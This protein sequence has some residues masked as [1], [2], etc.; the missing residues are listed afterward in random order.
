MKRFLKIFGLCFGCTIVGIALIFGFAWLFGAFTEKPVKP[1]DIAFVKEE[2][3][4]STAVALRV[5]TKTKDV[6]QKNINISVY[7]KG[8]LDVPSKVTLG[9]DFIAWPIKADDGYN[10]GGIVKVKADFNGLLIAECY[11]KVDVPVHEIVV[12][13]EHTTLSK[14]EQISFGTDVV[15]ARA[16]NPWQTDSIPSDMNLYD[17]RQKSLYYFLYD[18]EGFLMDTSKA[19]FYTAKYGATNKLLV[20]EANLNAKIIATEICSFY[21]KAFCFPTFAKE[22]REAI[23]SANDLIHKEL[24]QVDQKYL[25]LLTEASSPSGDND[26]QFVNVAD[27]YI[28]SFTS[29]TERINAFLYET[30]Y[31]AARNASPESTAFNLDMKLHP[32]EGSSGYT[33]ENLDAFIDNIIL[34]W[35][36]EGTEVEVIKQGQFTEGTPADWKWSIRPKTYNKDFEPAELKATIKYLDKD[37]EE[38]T[39]ERNFYVDIRT[40]A[41]AGITADK[42]EDENGEY[43]EYISLNS[44]STETDSIKL[45]EGFTSTTTA[46]GLLS[47]SYKYFT[48][49]PDTA[50]PYSTFSL[51]KFFL[52]S[53]TVTKPT[54]TGNYKVTF[55]FEIKKADNYRI[56]LPS[57]D[58][59]Q[60]EISYFKLN[61]GTGEYEEAPAPSGETKGKYR[62]EF[63]YTKSSAVAATDDFFIGDTSEPI[64]INNLLYFEEGSEYPFCEV[65]GV[66]IKTF[67]NSDTMVITRQMAEITA[68]GYGNFT[69]YA[70][71][72]VADNNGAIIYDEDGNFTTLTT[73]P[74]EVKVTNSVKSISLNISDSTGGTNGVDEGDFNRNVVIDENSDYYIYIGPTEE[75]AL[76]VLTQA[77]EKENFKVTYKVKAQYKNADDMVINS[78]SLTIGEIVEDIDAT[79]TTLIGYKFL[80]QVGNV[81][82]V[83]G[84][85]GE[86]ASILFNITF[87]VSGS[88]FTLTKVIEVRD[89]VLKEAEI[90]YGESSVNTMQI[91]ARDV[92]EGGTIKWQE[93]SNSADVD[94]TKFS[95]NFASEYGNVNVAPNI[96]FRATNHTVNLDNLV[97]AVAGE[98]GK[99]QLSIKNVPYFTD[100]IDVVITM[101]YS[102]S[103]DTINKRYVYNDRLQIYELESYEDTTATYNLKIYGFN[104]SYDI[105]NQSIVGIKG[106]PVNIID[107]SYVTI[108]IKAAKGET[109]NKPIT[110]M[111][112]FSMIN[113]EYLSFSGTTIEI[114]KSI[115]TPQQATVTLMIGSNTFTTHNLTFKSP[116]TITQNNVPVIEA[117]AADVNIATAFSIK[118][119]T[120]VVDPRLIKFSFGDSVIPQNDRKVSDYVSITSDGKVSVKYVPYDFGVDVHITIYEQIDDTL[121]YGAD[122][123]EDKG[124]WVDFKLSIINDYYSNNSV[125]V[126]TNAGLGN[127][128]YG[129]HQNNYINIDDVYMGNDYTMTLTF[130]DNLLDPADDSTQFVYAGL[131]DP[132]LG[133]CIF[134]YD[135]VTETPLPVRVTAHITIPD[136]GDTIVTF[137]VYVNQYVNIDFQNNVN[138]Q[139]GGEGMTINIKELYN[140]TDYLDNE[141]KLDSSEDVHTFGFSVAS[142]SE[143]L[144]SIT[145]KDDGDVVLKA[146]E[147]I[148]TEQTAYI[149]VTRKVY[150]GAMA[151]YTIDYTLAVT[152]KPAM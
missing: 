13:T 86:T 148:T 57:G 129:N 24:D 85:N 48:V 53:D 19:Y 23:T 11:V 104:I 98:D 32:T 121:G 40:R 25:D 78:E 138:L 95:F 105:R 132:T 70:S 6:N 80:L 93:R 52:P 119:D 18:D 77:I 3:T 109:V 39:L 144:I 137:M 67:F 113:T 118:Q 106:I 117:P 28:D 30:S 133:Y 31:L 135:V 21:V 90:K 145:T 75:T 89:H 66:R 17:D 96:T 146:A 60:G 14:G 108:S 115:T 45:E 35:T 4:T 76:E 69:V 97:T 103:D 125:F 15:P 54:A 142:G 1:K 122:N 62:V 47:H 111:V 123:L 147:G 64:E 73:K 16:L 51:I 128:I 2:V 139:S 43:K 83:E 136:N 33:Y 12:K 71:V 5:T 7:P 56:N 37:L 8:I 44:D 112:S 120:Q 29:T 59:I 100:G 141:V 41:V 114:L 36:G 61:E 124:T 9:E 72:V 46:S 38:R 126:G 68:T 151:F 79:T 34:E 49:V 82:S 116:Y 42:F 26:G 140:I 88:D 91:Y 22:D 102:G 65:N 152:V 134:A 143:E 131:K 50:Y 81:Y 74:I 10:V 55:E 107:A 99:Y 101:A 84:S 149:I 27:V 92:L 110:D 87:S 94:L 63:I 20:N 150:N 130:E 127:N 58:K